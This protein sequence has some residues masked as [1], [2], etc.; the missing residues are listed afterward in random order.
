MMISPEWYKEEQKD[1]SYQELL[2]VREELLEEIYA[3][4]K[5]TYDPEMDGI[6]PAPDVIYQCNLQYL[7]KLC[8]LIVEKYRQEYEEE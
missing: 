5:H 1:K 4:E 6:C 2:K 7:G 8:E 3:F